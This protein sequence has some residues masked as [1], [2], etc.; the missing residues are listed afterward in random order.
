[1]IR[2]EVKELVKLLGNEPRRVNNHRCS[3][4]KNL[5]VDDVCWRCR[6]FFLSLFFFFFSFFFMSEMMFVFSP[7]LR[8]GLH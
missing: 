7:K 6:T 5:D 4:H 2:D 3:L 1:M 8:T